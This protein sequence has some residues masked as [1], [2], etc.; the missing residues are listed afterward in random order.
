VAT[1]HGLESINHVRALMQRV[2]IV[3]VV[4]GAV[5]LVQGSIARLM[6]GERYATYHEVRQVLAALS[7]VL[8]ADL[9]ADGSVRAAAAWNR[10]VVEHDREI[11][12]RLA[13]SAA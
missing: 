5:L 6:G 13:D 10:W 8:P 3:H 12:S 7:D 9:R 11:R 4:L 1:G 2:L